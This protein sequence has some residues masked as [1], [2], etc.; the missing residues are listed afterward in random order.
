MVLTWTSQKP[1]PSSSRANSPS[2]SCQDQSGRPLELVP[3]AN[4]QR[5]G[6]FPGA[7]ALVRESGR[8]ETAPP[9]RKGRPTSAPGAPRRGRRDFFRRRV[10]WTGDFPTPE[11]GS[12]GSIPCATP[13]AERLGTTV[14]E[15][16][17]AFFYSVGPPGCRARSAK[18]CDLVEVSGHTTLLTPSTRRIPD[19]G[20][21][22]D[23][24]RDL[25]ESTRRDQFVPPAPLDRFEGRGQAR[26]PA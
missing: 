1:S 24:G 19:V 3:G 10:A 6:F 25:D 21:P 13:A 4:G 12:P 7:H 15:V 5:Q 18:D 2:A 8:P 17:R 20:Q 26:P 22:S 14:L 9:G 23:G 11:R 16:F